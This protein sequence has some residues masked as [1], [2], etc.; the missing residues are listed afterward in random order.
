MTATVTA[1]IPTVGRPS[2]NRAVASVLGQ[3]RRVDEII[4]VADTDNQVTLPSDDRIKLLR[5][6]FRGG[7]ARCRQRGIDAARGEVIALLDDDDEW[8][9]TKLDR[10]LKTV[11]AETGN[12]WIVSS[13]VEAL[14]PGGRT[15]IWPRRL[16]QPQESVADYWFRCRSF[17]VGGAALQTSTLCFPAD[18]AQMVPWDGS[19][20]AV[21]DEP[22]WLIRVQ[23]AFPDVR[24]IQLPDV[25]SVYN[26][27]D[28]SV[29]RQR[30]DHTQRYIDW[31]LQN[32][33]T[34]SPRVLGD[35]LCTSP[36]SAAVSAGSLRGVRDAMRCA[37]RHGRP[38]FFAVAY[39]LL[40]AV[41]VVVHAAVSAVRR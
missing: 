18:L 16:I 30:V 12:N 1:V 8:Y 40:N 20:G 11:A 25:L 7:P 17:S 13:R 6:P 26:I 19:A 10:Q 39:A 38:G 9:R 28:T 33:N 15:R 5:M 41:R 31:G 36:V 37:F 2:L 35:Y 27:T 24:V 34:E 3:T 4:V 14:G 29:S 22:N 23:R 21:N 32:L